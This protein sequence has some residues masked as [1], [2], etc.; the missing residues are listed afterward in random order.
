MALRYHHQSRR[1]QS[2]FSGAIGRI[3][4][5]LIAVLALLTLLALVLV[6]GATIRGPLASLLSDRLNATVTIE[7]AAFSP[8][9]PDTLKLNGVK[10]RAQDFEGVIDEAYVEIDLTRSLFSDTL[11]VDDLYLNAGERI[12][13][14]CL[15]K[16]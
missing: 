15:I 6:N 5:V 11:Y 1:Q 2:L 16:P 8:L 3:V 12:L 9:Y 7:D 14:P 4:A 10:I 13:A